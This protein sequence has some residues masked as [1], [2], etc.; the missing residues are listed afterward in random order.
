MS[1]LRQLLTFAVSAAVLSS[2]STS[3]AERVS[4]STV[5]SLPWIS[6]LHENE[7]PLQAQQYDSNTVVI[8]QSLRTGF[9][10]PF[11]Y[12]LF[13]EE[14]ALLID[15]GAGGVDLRSKVDLQIEAWLEETGREN[16]SLVV[17]HSHAHGDHVA[18]D[19]QFTDRADTVIVGHAA[20]DVAEFFRIDSWPNGNTAFDLG[21][22]IVDII[23][24]PGH[25][26]AHVMVYDRSTRLLFSGD[27]LY[28]GRLYFQCGK[29]DL[30]RSSID[31]VADFTNTRDVSWIL[32]AHIELALK[33]GKSFNSND[34]VRTDERLLEMTPATITDVKSALLQMG[35]RLRVEPYDDFI[36]FPHPADPRGKKPPNWCLSLDSAN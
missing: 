35:D 36:L 18:G 11:I 5:F 20:E 17:M 12:L 8:R 25:H 22:R 29:A 1:V 34:L 10:A 6:G 9:E 4:D 13:G 24:T 2:C 21:G 31:R 19:E 3:S 14:K 7:P 33:P 28:P 16:I 32:G 27:M 26:D 15:T 30:F 23:P